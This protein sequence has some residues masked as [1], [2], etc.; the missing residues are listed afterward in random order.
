MHPISK[1]K[2]ILTFTLLA[3]FLSSSLFL[4]QPVL[5]SCSYS[6]NLAFLWLFLGILCFFNP[7]LLQVSGASLDF[8]PWASSSPPH[9]HS[10]PLPSPSLP[11]LPSPSPFPDSHIPLLLPPPSQPAL[12][13]LLTPSLLL[14][15]VV[16][17]WRHTLKLL[18]LSGTQFFHLYKED[19]NS[20][21]LVG[22]LVAQ[23]V[24]IYLQ[25][26]QFNPWGW[27]VLEKGM[28]IHSSILILESPMMKSR[29]ARVMDCKGS[30][31]QLS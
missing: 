1:K 3:F 27:T 19:N 31:T 14:S 7:F 22:P 23:M 24:R 13:L 18:N 10:T 8:L 20:T 16:S 6:Q 29:R 2:A 11:P 5:S 17:V 9:S 4:S 15:Y 30:L 12:S 26:T 28:A 21:H 25:E